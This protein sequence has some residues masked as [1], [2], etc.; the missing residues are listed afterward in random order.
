MS[1][2]GYR[3]D[4]GCYG[5]E[6]HPSRKDAHDHRMW[7]I[8]SARLPGGQRRTRRSRNRIT[9]YHCETCGFWHV[10]RSKRRPR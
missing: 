5:K 9:I 1:D 6:K 2:G 7:L 3:P 8:K 4:K 10:G